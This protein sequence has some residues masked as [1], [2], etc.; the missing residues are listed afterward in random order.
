M[1]L[2]LDEV[3]IRSRVY[4]DTRIVEV[5]LWQFTGDPQPNNFYPTKMAAEVAALADR[6]RRS[7]QGRY[8]RVFHRV[9]TDA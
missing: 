1:I 8:A 4:D 9:F 3:T 7:P 6:E 2:N 5:T